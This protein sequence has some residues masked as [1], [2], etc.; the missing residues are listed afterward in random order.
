MLTFIGSHSLAE[1]LA[2]TDLLAGNQQGTAVGEIAEML[3]SHGQQLGVA[4]AAI[5]KAF[6]SHDAFQQ[7]GAVVLE[8]AEQHLAQIT[9]TAAMAQ[10]Q[11]RIGPFESLRDRRQV[12]MVGRRPLTGQVAVVA[13]GEILPTAPEPMGA[14]HRVFDRLTLETE[15]IRVVMVKMQHQTVALIASHGRRFGLRMLRRDTDLFEKVAHAHH[16]LGIEIG[17]PPC[18]A[19]ADPGLLPRRH[20]DAQPVVPQFPDLGTQGAKEGL[21]TGGTHAM[22]ER[23]GK[24]GAQGDEMRMLHQLFAV[25]FQAIEPG[26]SRPSLHLH[27]VNR[28]TAEAVELGGRP[29]GR[30]MRVE[31]VGLRYHGHGKQLTIG[32][33]HGHVGATGEM[34]QHIALWL[35]AIKRRGRINLRCPEMHRA[36]TN[37]PVPPSNRKGSR[38]ARGQ[39]HP[40]T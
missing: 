15:H 39:R 5:I 11:H 36:P 20:A 27:H 24:Q 25:P 38:P 8:V 3:P 33:V 31:L 21:N 22:A 1:K 23:M 4:E 12:G 2:S 32:L 40:G 19:A 26:R 35:G 9:F 17:L 16:R 28:L 6:N 18:T 10:Q 14:Q 29:K 37:G 13:M 30:L 34:P 7:I